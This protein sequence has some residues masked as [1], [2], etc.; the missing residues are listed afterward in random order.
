MSITIETDFLTFKIKE[1]DLSHPTIH[2]VL[3][4]S[5]FKYFSNLLNYSINTDYFVLTVLRS[6]HW[7]ITE[8]STNQLY[9]S[10]LLNAI[11]DINLDESIPL[12][13]DPSIDA[14][15]S[16][17]RLIIRIPKKKFDI[18]YE[19][20][21]EAFKPNGFNIHYYDIN[22]DGNLVDLAEYTERG[23]DGLNKVNMYITADYK[24]IGIKDFSRN[25]AISE[26]NNI[27][28]ASIN[29]ASIN[30]AYITAIY[31]GALTDSD[32]PL[33]NLELSLNIDNPA[34]DQ[35]VS[36]Y[37]LVAY[38][39]DKGLRISFNKYKCEISRTKGNYS[40]KTIIDK[41]ATK[42]WA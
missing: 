41:E 40:I 6:T 36:L 5:M 18:F 7:S 3:D 31:K 16:S 11:I 32:S 35:R 15:F 19:F 2:N 24:L 26:I 22:I 1:K 9:E 33:K 8:S 39:D 30:D 38:S 13:L 21:Y 17:V 4:F 42:I 10:D 12:D 20:N 23:I 28:D 29:D 25:N 27:N 14:Y 34:S 37:D